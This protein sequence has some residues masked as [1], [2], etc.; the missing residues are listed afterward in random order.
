MPVI[1]EKKRPEAKTPFNFT[2]DRSQ[3][4]VLSSSIRREAET[5]RLVSQPRQAKNQSPAKSTGNK[6]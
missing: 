6:R 2:Y 1:T 3:Y 5:G 4:V